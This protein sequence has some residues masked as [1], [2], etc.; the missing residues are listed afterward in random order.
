MSDNT[1]SEM[2]TRSFNEICDQC[3]ASIPTFAAQ[4]GHLECLKCFFENG[5]EGQSPWTTAYAARYGH[6]ECLKYLRSPKSGKPCPW[7]S[8]TTI[9]A[10]EGGHLECLKYAHSNGC[11]MN[12]NTATRAA[13]EGH[14]E[15]LKYIHSNGYTWNSDT[16]ARASLNGHL[17]CLEYIRENEW[18]WKVYILKTLSLAFSVSKSIFDLFLKT[19]N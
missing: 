7:D 10:A 9:L 15:C 13:E 18:S 1:I 4:N 12:S 17:E 16:A 2:T 14:L 19:K 8:W 5:Y 3:K 6:L 11:P